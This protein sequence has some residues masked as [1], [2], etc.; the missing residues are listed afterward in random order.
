VSAQGWAALPDDLRAQ[1]A[2]ELN[3]MTLESLSD[4]ESGLVDISVKANFRALG[5]R[6]AQQTPI[7]AEAIAA[8]PAAA[9]V[10]HLR[11]HGSARIEVPG[12][13]EVDI[14]DEDVVVTETPREGWA[15]VSEGGESLAL[16]LHLDDELLRA[17]MA[18]EIVRTLQEG[19]KSA[20]LEV[21]DRIRVWWTTG[22]AEAEAAVTQHAAEIADEVLAVEFTREEAPEGAFEVASELPVGFWLAPVR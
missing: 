1:V 4:G 6:F 8:S 2:E 3:V 5:K 16:D 21:S 15:V 7:V 11:S 18:R 20:G 10:E 9:L 14:T 12:I 17:G 19:R 13:G 22:D